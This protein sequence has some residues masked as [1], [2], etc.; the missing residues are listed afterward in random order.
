MS[1]RIPLGLAIGVVTVL[2]VA[3]FVSVNSAI[4]FGRWRDINPANYALAVTGDF[5]GL[6]VRNGGTGSIGGGDG[7][8]VG[9]DGAD[10]L[11]SHYDGFSWQIM[12]SPI[13]SPVT[14]RSVHFCTAPGAPS[15]GLCSP[16]GD[17]TDGWIVGDKA[18]AAAALYWDGSALTPV[19]TG[20]PAGTALNSVFMV[21]HS[22][23]YGSGCPG[24]PGFSSGLTYAVGSLGGFGVIFQFNG[25]PKAGGGWTQQ[26]INGLP[27]SALATTYNGVYMFV[28]QAGN[29]AGFAVGEG[30]TGGIIARLNGGTW[31]DATVAVG[32]GMAFKAVFVDRGNPADAWAVGFDS[33]NGIIWHFATGIWTGPVSPGVAPGSSLRS[34]FLTSTN[35]GWIV[36]TLGRILHSTTLG[37]ANAWLA[38]STPLQTAVG[39]GIDLFG[40]SF[41]GGGNGWAVGEEGVILHT[42]NAG[43]PGVPSPC[44]GGSTSITD[45]PSLNAVF[46]LGT[47][48]AWAGGMPDAG[49]TEHSMIHWDGNKWHRVSAA[50]LNV[51]PSVLEI[52]SMYMLGSSDGWAVGGTAGVPEALHWDGNSWTGQPITG[53]GGVPPCQPRSV[54]MLS[55]GVGGDGWAVGTGGRIWRFQSGSWGLIAS[56]TV[57]D[58]NGVFIS[59]PGSNVNAGWAVGKTGTVLKLQI[60]GGVPTWVV[61]GP[62]LG[63]I[64]ELFGV[65]FKDSN[66]GWIVGAKGTI[67]TTVDGGASWSGGNNQVTGAPGTTVLRSVF[68][69]IYGVGSG[70]GDGWAVGDDGAA[71]TALFAH[72]DGSTWTNTP[73]APPLG[74]T[75]LALHSVYVKGPEDGFAVGEP[76]APGTLSGIAHLDPLNPTQ[77]PVTTTS[78]ITTTSSTT[79]SISSSTSVA[80]SSVSSTS[81]SETSTSSVVTS[82]S[83]ITSSTESTSSE[84]SSSFA[85]VTVTQSS[86]TTTPLVMPA[87]PGF[88]I[89]SIIAGIVLGLTTLVMIRRRKK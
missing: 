60:V 4:T 58:L 13:A 25:N 52:W 27:A 71:P 88:P 69:D 12:G 8:A 53:C 44:W 28:D 51:L 20:L 87:V 34:V 59:N 66:H 56:P 85:T 80:S 11:I 55:G 89:E 73:L 6:Y 70:N 32:A 62:L 14:Y 37:G 2:L 41:P 46:M 35:E 40:L 31:T 45:S 57:T 16:N 21:C 17:G 3:S 36:G 30:V 63:V 18:G 48:D 75:G 67:L 10:P 9:G 77:I 42:E 65:Y 68:V 79:S 5:N 15:V 84:T 50:P 1:R 47:N 33:V 54:F 29:L 81:T 39:A 38:L 26:L 82:T 64:D 83:E 86:S 76:I 7:W 72:W 23:P 74:G 22:P 43:C 49:L 78:V 24:G 19:T 61:V